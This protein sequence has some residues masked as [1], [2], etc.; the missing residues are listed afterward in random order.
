MVN[1]SALSRSAEATHADEA[2]LIEAAR[3]GDVAARD[4]LTRRYLPAVYRLAL[5]ILGEPGPAEDATQDAFVN[6]LQALSGFRGE[7]S[8]RTWLLRI[9]ANAA[10]SAGRRSSRRREVPLTAVAEPAVPG[11]DA[12]ARVEREA[13][14]AR[15][16]QALTRLPPKQRL[17]VTL[18]TQQGLSFAEVGVLLNCSE[19]AARVNYHLGVKRLRELLT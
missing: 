6:A 4:A 15:V 10:Y 3:G 7:S 13:D 19:G 18:R 8:F 5:R 17:A 11:P 14:A 1:P 12:A 16:E 2:A 9:A